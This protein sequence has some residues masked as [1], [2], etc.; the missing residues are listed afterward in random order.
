MGN[1]CNFCDTANVDSKNEINIEDG[2]DDSRNARMRK[3]KSK[4]EPFILKF[5]ELKKIQ[6]ATQEAS[7]D[8]D[9]N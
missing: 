5:L 2:R 6:T 8:K 9:N 4:K 3:V 7:S 1:H